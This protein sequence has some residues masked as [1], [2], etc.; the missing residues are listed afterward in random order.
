MVRRSGLGNF[1]SVDAEVIVMVIF[2][3]RDLDI[4]Y[5]QRIRR[6]KIWTIG[7]LNPSTARGE[8]LSLAAIVLILLSFCH[9]SL[10]DLPTNK[11]KI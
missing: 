6:Y 11:W 5:A 4:E 1:D 10:L 2:R 9:R 8:L 7:A 3:M